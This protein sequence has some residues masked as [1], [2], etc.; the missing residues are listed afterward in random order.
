[1]TPRNR[2]RDFWT[3]HV[4][5]VLVLILCTVVTVIEFRRA[6]EGV[7]RAWIYL[8][9][10]PL[11]AAFAVWMWYRFTH[12]SGGGF[13]RRWRERIANLEAEADRQERL[14]RERAE[15]LRAQ[16]EQEATD[17][18]LA[19]WREYQRDLRRQDQGPEAG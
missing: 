3:L 4:P 10:W 13:L 19:A 9:E 5:L 1:M 2:Q 11:I 16:A 18:Q 6:N 7:W 12:E 17:P 14:E 8:F 15:R